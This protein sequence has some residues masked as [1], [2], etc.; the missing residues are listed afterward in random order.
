[1]SEDFGSSLFKIQGGVPSSADTLSVLHVI[2]TSKEA[3]QKCSGLSGLVSDLDSRER[4]DR[5]RSMVSIYFAVYA[6]E[7]G[8]L[9]PL[10]QTTPDFVRSCCPPPFSKWREKVVAIYDKKGR[11]SSATVDSSVLSVLQ[12]LESLWGVPGYLVRT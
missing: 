7:A 2:V 12:A 5:C 8:I 3:R 6:P 1:M 4:Q 10:F 9:L 11:P